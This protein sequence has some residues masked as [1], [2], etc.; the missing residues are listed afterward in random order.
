[1]AQRTNMIIF[2]HT[3]VAPIGVDK[4]I[5]TR[6]PTNAQTTPIVPDAITTDI[7]LLKTLSAE[8][9]GKT[10]SAEIRSEPTSSANSNSNTTKTTNTST[11]KI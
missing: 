6:I 1:M 5:E 4:G 11:T 9:T 8:R 2:T 3:T 10:M 7:K